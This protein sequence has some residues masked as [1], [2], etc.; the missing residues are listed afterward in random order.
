MMSRVCCPSLDASEGSTSGV[1]LRRMWLRGVCTAPTTGRA[2]QNDQIVGKDLL[3]VEHFLRVVNLRAGHV[4]GGH[5]GKSIPRSALPYFVDRKSEIH[6]ILPHFLGTGPTVS[7]LS[8]GELEAR[9][10][11]SE[12]PSLRTGY[13]PF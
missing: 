10:A 5:G 7:E 8:G 2:R 12:A 13:R 11:V 1:S 3:N 4:G 6:S 9:E